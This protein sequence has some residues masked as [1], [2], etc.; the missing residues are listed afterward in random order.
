MRPLLTSVLICIAAAAPGRATTT[1]PV[2]LGGRYTNVLNGFS[3]R[4][5]A[6]TERL[7]R[8]SRRRLVAWVQRDEATGAIRM[9]LEVLR[10]RQLPAKLPMD[11]YAKDIA[12][13]LLVTSRLNVESTELGTVAGRPAMHFRGMTHGEL[14]LWC[15]QTWV[16]VR[17]GPEKPD[18]AGEARLDEYLVL[19]LTGPG[20]DKARL[21]A[22][23]TACAATLRL[24]DPVAARR[25]RADSLARGA[26]VLAGWT[27]AKLRALLSPRPGYYTMVLAGRVIGFLRVTEAIGRPFD[28]A[29]GLWVVRWGCLKAPDQPRQLIHEELFCTADRQVEQWR[30]A[31][32]N[33]EG[34][35][36]TRSFQEGIKQGNVLLVGSRARG[37]PPQSKKFVM[38]EPIRGAY[39]P[40]AMSILV[41]Q[42]IDRSKPTLYGFAVFNPVAG[43][44]DLRTV[45]VVGP[46]GLSVS[47]RTVKATRLTDQKADDAPQTD[48][49]VDAAGRLLRTRA[50]DKGVVIQ[51]SSQAAVVRLFATEMVELEKLASRARRLR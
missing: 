37:R 29:T 16:K 10:T 13:R 14:K 35:S 24:F 22:V 42:L 38:P 31:L 39:L 1:A 41:P 26:K 25:Q 2:L 30:H 44:F 18:A 6:G 15:R 17:S 50:P 8:T 36:A 5:P 23:M 27:D 28:G 46:E 49:W 4:P 19:N 9:S 20:N 51:R 7:R 33:G 45:R 47:G 48:V 32:M 43:G 40:G 11:Q 34:R 12:K 21:D 3:L